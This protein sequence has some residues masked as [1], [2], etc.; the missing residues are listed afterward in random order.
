MAEQKLIGNTE[1]LDS[2]KSLIKDK[3]NIIDD[4]IDNIYNSLSLIM[5]NGTW[6]GQAA[7]T[8]YNKCTGSKDSL[9][10]VVKFLNDYADTIGNVN[11]KFGELAK[12]VSDACKGV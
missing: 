11:G 1:N 5:K 2:L 4:N 6:E 10:S 3:A 7:N 8:F 12:S 9:K